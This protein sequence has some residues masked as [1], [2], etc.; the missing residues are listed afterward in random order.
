[1]ARRAINMIPMCVIFLLY[2][3]CDLLSLSSLS[4]F[5]RYPQAVGVLRGRTR[6]SF[7]CSPRASGAIH[8]KEI[9]KHTECRLVYRN[10]FGKLLAR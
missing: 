3:W 6:V 7:K 4:T 5:T 2:Q 10:G 8:L 1:M 9:L